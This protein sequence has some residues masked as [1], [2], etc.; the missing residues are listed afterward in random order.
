MMPVTNAPTKPKTRET[1]PPVQK[2]ATPNV[3]NT[4]KVTETKVAEL[5]PALTKKVYKEPTVVH[6]VAT[7]DKL[8]RRVMISP[9]RNVDF[10]VPG[11]KDTD[12]V[13]PDK[14]AESFA[15]FVK[16]RNDVGSGLV[17]TCEDYVIELIVEYAKLKKLTIII[18]RPMLGPSNVIRS[19]PIDELKERMM[20]NMAAEDLRRND[21][22]SFHGNSKDPSQRNG[23]QEGDVLFSMNEATTSE[24]R[25]AHHVMVVKEVGTVT[26]KQLND[27]K[28]KPNYAGNFKVGDRYAII[29]QGNTRSDELLDS[30]R[31]NTSSPNKSYY[32]GLPIQTATYNLT[33][34]TYV[35][36]YG[37]K[38]VTTEFSKQGSGN[39]DIGRVSGYGKLSFLS[40]RENIIRLI[41]N[42]A[43]FFKTEDIIYTMQKHR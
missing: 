41:D 13:W 12:T 30:F 34:D 27:W 33:T 23:I 32:V 1:P 20:E 25:H 39:Q 26:Q 29:V 40:I 38:E 2:K 9:Y 24:P 43:Y 31:M 11:I 8:D 37:N 5:P 10:K 21:I 17:R 4:Q 36:D 16:Q 15:N 6:Q 18:D 3:V 7:I 28:N 14:S 42:I 22:F 19:M 35:R